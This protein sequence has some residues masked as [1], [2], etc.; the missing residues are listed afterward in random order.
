M[1]V[2]QRLVRHPI[3]FWFVFCGEL[4]ERASFYGMKG[5]LTLYLVCAYHYGDKNAAAATNL[6]TAAC[7]LMPLAG[8]Y[9]ADRYIGKY[10]TIVVFSIPYILGH[11]VLGTFIGRP[12]LMLA[13]GLLAL[14]SGAIKPNASTLMGSIYERQGKTELLSEAFM[15][16]YAAINIGAFATSFALPLVQDHYAKLKEATLGAEAAQVYGYQIALMYPTILMAVALAVF[17]W[18]KRFYPEEKIV[19]VQKTPRQRAAERATLVRLSGVFL[20]I[21]A[22]WFFYDQQSSIWIAFAN[23]HMDM[24]LRPFNWQVLPNQLNA[25]NAWL[26]IALTPFFNWL[27]EFLKARRGG[28][29]MLATQKMLLGFILVVGCA[30]VMSIAGYIS[31]AGHPSVWFFVVATVILT[32]AE[33]CVSVVGLEF[34]F[35]Q[36]SEETKSTVTAV[37]W[38]MVFLG[39]S[40]GALFI[41][42]MYDSVSAGTFFVIQAVIMVVVAI[43]FRFVARTFERSEKAAANEAELSLDV[44]RP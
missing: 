9:L 10:K 43:L 44:G 22:F 24:W 17:A 1:N 12:W 32:M 30:A 34:A 2:F 4:A 5:L 39:D 38:L 11:V 27:W 28:H 16:Y 35:T 15:Y 40:V 14:G 41:D 3:G 8:G 19:R 6:F 13:L 18:G 37:F 42:Q 29:P 33:L 36:A 26:I 21:A 31:I 23:S 25:L 20:S 7:Y